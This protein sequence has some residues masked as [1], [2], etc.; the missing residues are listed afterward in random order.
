MQ[1]HEL[2]RSPSS[3]DHNQYIHNGY[4]Y[5]SNYCAGLRV[6]DT[7]KMVTGELSEK[8]YFDVAPECNKAV[9]SGNFDS[10]LSHSHSLTHLGTWSNYPYF[11]SGTIAVQSIEKGLF[12]VK[13]LYPPYLVLLV[14]LLTPS[15]P[16][17]NFNF[18]VDCME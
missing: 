16:S 7:T 8:G 18:V 1:K 6:L 3:L 13:V 4:S 15:R 12:L 10:T 9:F 17:F 2:T 14:V 11:A 5:Q